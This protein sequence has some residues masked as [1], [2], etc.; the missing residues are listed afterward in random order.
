[1]KYTILIL[2]FTTTFYGYGK[3]EYKYGKVTTEQLAQKKYP[4]DSLTGAVILY[5]IG[6]INRLLFTKREKI[7]IYDKNAFYLANQTL[8]LY[9][10]KF[11]GD[12]VSL[13]NIKGKTYNLENGKIVED[14]LSKKTVRIDKLDDYHDIVHFTF[15]NVKEGSIIEY[16]IQLNGVGIPTWYFQQYYPVEYS[17]FKTN[18][19]DFFTF[20]K[21]TKGYLNI[22]PPEEEGQSTVVN[23]YYGDYTSTVNTNIW[24][25]KNIPPFV[26]E[27][28]IY[29]ADNYISQISHE[30]LYV[31]FPR[32]IEQDFTTNW[33]EIENKLLKDSYHGQIINIASGFM[34]AEYEKVKNI[35]DNKERLDACYK[36]IQNKMSWNG[37][38]SI[39]S[40]NIK[41]A[42]KETKGSCA[43]INFLLLR[44]LKD[45]NIESYPVILSTRDNGFV[46]MFPSFSK[47]NYMVVLAKVN[48]QSF[49][50]D[51]TDKYLP[52]NI[53]PERCLN[54]RGLIIKDGAVQWVDLTPKY[55]S[56]A[57][58]SIDAKLTDDGTITGKTTFKKSNYA[59]SKARK[60]LTQNSN[61]SKKETILTNA[62][63]GI[64]ISNYNVLNLDSV[65]LP[66]I[67]NFEFTL[68]NTESKNAKTLLLEPILFEKI[69][70]NPFKTPQRTYPVELDVP[71]EKIYIVN[72][73]LPANYTVDERP[74]NV[75]FSMPDNSAKFSYQINLLNNTLQLIAKL[76]IKNTI[77][78]QTQY[79]DLKEFFAQYISKLNEP[80]LLQRK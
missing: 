70:E 33:S 35:M 69:V 11:S 56:S 72:I 42:Y 57:I 14:D 34:N 47:F 22:P 16:E 31:K 60:I 30:L 66:V 78:S 64:E 15:S 28:Y 4:K 9:N 44:L 52:I 65:S 19:S 77:Y 12:D 39:F 74:K 68:N 25:M 21:E 2:F 71:T 48:G 23:S 63:N 79:P 7:K 18:I 41:D 10:P 8:V 36:A 62:A 27:P 3:D 51:A 26:P 75:S 24:K 49:L 46:P 53:L 32:Q 73:S 29:C 43:D 17:E 40:L 37:S 50:L 13:Y 59:A 55:N 58:T 5:S 80:I 54:D 61:D 45:C 1:M 67:E 76:N 20:R 6:E 38:K